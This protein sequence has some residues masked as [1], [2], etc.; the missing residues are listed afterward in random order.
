MHAFG[1]RPNHSKFFYQVLQNWRERKVSE[2]VDLIQKMIKLGCV[3][4]RFEELSK[5]M[6]RA[7]VS[8]EI[9]KAVYKLKSLSNFT[10]AFTLFLEYNRMEAKCFDPVMATCIL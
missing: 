1:A 8:P 6:W 7:K 4:G 3:L 10:D 2:T 9:Y 5:V